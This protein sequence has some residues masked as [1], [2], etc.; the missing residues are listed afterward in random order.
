MKFNYEKNREEITENANIVV[1]LE[2]YIKYCI[3][4]K[5]DE[6]FILRYQKT[7]EKYKNKLDKGHKAEKAYFE[8]K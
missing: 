6:E 2:S 3:E 1:S 8:K 4:I 5:M 7:L